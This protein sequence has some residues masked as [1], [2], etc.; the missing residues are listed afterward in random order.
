MAQADVQV[1]R[2]SGSPLFSLPRCRGGVKDDR[3][4]QQWPWHDMAE[5]ARTE[6]RSSGILLVKCHRGALCLRN[7][8]I[9]RLTLQDSRSGGLSFK[10]Q[11][12]CWSTLL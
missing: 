2:H 10:D 4:L 9:S 1:D 5:G 3:W 8:D 12:G 7:D 6:R 11:R